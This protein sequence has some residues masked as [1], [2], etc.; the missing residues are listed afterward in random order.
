MA[1]YRRAPS[2]SSVRGQTAYTS[3]LTA[4]L[5]LVERAAPLPAIRGARDIHHAQAMI[6]GVAARV[7]DNNDVIARLQGLAGNALAAELATGA[8]FH[9]PALHHALFVGCFHVHEGVRVAIQELN[10]VA[11][12]L[13]GLIFKIS[14]SER[15]MGKRPAAGH[16]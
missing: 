15:V 13:L 3:L 16:E 11:L 2:A 4:T 10:Q 7:A 14:R 9:G 12:D 1:P 6:L 5:S 8:P